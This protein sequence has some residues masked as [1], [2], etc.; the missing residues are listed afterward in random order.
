MR[1]DVLLRVRLLRP[2]GRAGG[3]SMMCG[4]CE[5]SRAGFARH[6]QERKRQHRCQQEHGASRRECDYRQQCA[7]HLGGVEMKSV[8][9][10]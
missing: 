2:P 6:A 3:R 4:F 5:V 8:Y 1:L 7:A 9:H 10:A